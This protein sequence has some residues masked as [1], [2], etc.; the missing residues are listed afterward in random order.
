MEENTIDNKKKEEVIRF[1][2]TTDHKEK[3][4]RA[5]T[6]RGLTVSEYLRQS[7]ISKM[8]RERPIADKEAEMA[9]LLSARNKVDNRRRSAATAAEKDECSLK[10]K[11]ISK[12]LKALRHD[13]NMAKGIFP[14]IENLKE[15]LRI[16]ME[17]ELEMLPKETGAKIGKWINA[18][19]TIEQ[20]ANTPRVVS[21]FVFMFFII[22]PL[23]F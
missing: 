7:V 2:T 3:I 12:E 10:R 19:K 17:Q 11:A 5:A 22:I 1:K 13:N 14:K 15:K 6:K 4:E 18:T 16:E 21:F 23:L 20:A 9:M 8:S